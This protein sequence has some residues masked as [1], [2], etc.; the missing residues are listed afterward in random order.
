MAN[1]KFSQFTPSGGGYT[2]ARAST[3]V[4]G[5]DNSGGPDNVRLSTADL[6]GL[7]NWPEYQ[8]ALDGTNPE[9]E[10]TQSTAYS[11]G[12][13]SG[14]VL[15]T[16]S[17]ATTVTRAS[18][19]SINISS[20]DTTSLPVK[21]AAGTTQFTSDATTGVRFTGTGATTV[22]F[23]AGTQLVTI[24]STDTNYTYTLS[25]ADA[26]PNIDIELTSGGGGTDSAYTI[27][28]GTNITLTEDGSNTGFT[29][30]ADDTNTTYTLTAPNAN[31]IRLQD[32]G[33][34]NNDVSISSG[35]GITLNQAA[36]NNINITNT[37]SFTTQST[38]G[39]ISI[40][41]SPT[42]TG[43]TLNVDQASGIVTPGPYTNANITVDT[44]GRVTAAANGSGGGGNGD[45]LKSTLYYNDAASSNT[46]GIWSFPNATRFDQVNFTTSVGGLIQNCG[47]TFI[48]PS[49]GNVR[50]EIHFYQETG[51]NLGE[52]I[53]IGLH[54]DFGNGLTGSQLAY[55]WVNPG[56]DNDSGDQMREVTVFM[57]IAYDQFITGGEEPV[58]VPPGSPVTLWLKG[59][60]SSSSNNIY[61]SC[62]GTRNFGTNYGLNLVTNTQL[63]GGPLTITAYSLDSTLYSTNPGG[64]P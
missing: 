23:T 40:S 51:A 32:S 59:C 31:T 33:G 28:A 44:Y 10:F 58:T 60:A 45:V 43:G 55:G 52:D 63:S 38:T 2:P 30:D 6:E 24:D 49:S 14:T 5:Y 29:I 11:Y 16:G 39:T 54:N 25:T 12:G 1:I 57:D 22:S 41:G 9:I 19:T 15:F 34:A 13:A 37:G 8:I 64:T 47:I 53:F 61:F 46:P 27:T 50:I 35:A 48:V 42:S 17:G 18:A 36:T 62:T 20:T 26:S 56:A 21:N 7:L 4:V 3:F